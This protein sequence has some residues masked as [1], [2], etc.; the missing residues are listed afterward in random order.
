M[1]QS[2]ST[3]ELARMWDVSESTVKRWS[4]A[5]ALRCR[6]TVGGHRK[7]ELEDIL[8]FQ[9][10]CGLG[11]KGL[12]AEKGCAEV[13]DEL[14]HLL[15]E[16]DLVGLAERFG[17]A[18]LSAH[19]SFPSS[20][21]E[22]Y[23]RRGLSLAIIGEEIIRPAMHQIGEMW[24]AGKI[25][26]LVEHLATMAT[27]RA[28]ADLHSKIEKKQN[29]DRVAL[30]GC[31]EGELHQLASSLVRS[32]LEIEGWE[33]TYL[34]QH[35]P[36]FSYAEAAAMLKPALVCISIT[37]ADNLER[38]ARDYEGLRRAASKQGAKIVIGGAALKDEKVR[39][40][41]RGAIYAATLHDLLTVVKGDE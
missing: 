25:S 32:L 20:L 37:M 28:L 5:G 7:F 18:V 9:N 39:A 24:R 12:A 22:Q 2:Y 8:E 27:I 13:D 40:R 4:D 35:T 3:K 23:H 1:K 19:D 41:F 36:L 26:V 15:A 21:L 38:A 34:G 14:E 11:I 17:Q 33:V 10:H 30:V 29:V 16:P 6:K 31:S